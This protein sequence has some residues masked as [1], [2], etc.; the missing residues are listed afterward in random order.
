[1]TVSNGNAEQPTAQA[2]KGH[3]SPNRVEVS[4]EGRKV[5]PPRMLKARRARTARAKNAV[6]SS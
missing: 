1:M 5:R 4:G 6:K 2:P 3:S